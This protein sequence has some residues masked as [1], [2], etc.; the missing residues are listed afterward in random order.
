MARLL[1]PLGTATALVVG[2]LLLAAPATATPNDLVTT[3]DQAVVTT[4]TTSAPTVHVESS[5][6]VVL[7]VGVVAG[8]TGSAY[9]VRRSRSCGPDRTDRAL[10]SG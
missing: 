2:G 7:A 10:V 5:L 8:A 4:V 9:L 6:A 1:A 3:S